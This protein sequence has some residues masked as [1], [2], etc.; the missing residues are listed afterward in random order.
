[1]RPVEKKRGGDG[2]V[3]YFGVNLTILDVELDSSHSSQS[4]LLKLLIS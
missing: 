2:V 1:M 3:K 4:D